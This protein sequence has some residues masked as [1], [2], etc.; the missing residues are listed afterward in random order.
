[1]IGD[2]LP[3]FNTPDTLRGRTSASDR[4]QPSSERYRSI[5]VWLPKSWLLRTG[6]RKYGLIRV[7][8]VP[9]SGLADAA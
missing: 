2:A 8:E 1:L 9:S 3:I 5:P 6:W 7:R 4:N